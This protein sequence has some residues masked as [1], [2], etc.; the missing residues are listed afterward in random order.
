MEEESRVVGREV[1]IRGRITTDGIVATTVDAEGVMDITEIT[2]NIAL[3]ELNASE[4]EDLIC[5]VSKTG[6]PADGITV[7]ITLEA[8]DGTVV[9]RIVHKGNIITA[10]DGKTLGSK[11]DDAVVK[12]ARL[13]GW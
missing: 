9:Q 8:A 6:K 10:I 11:S 13:V 3:E 5:S 12:G 1:D 2:L 7:E 4:V